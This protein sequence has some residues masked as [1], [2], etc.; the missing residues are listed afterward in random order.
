MR[1][2]VLGLHLDLLQ[3]RP[4]GC[5]RVR[6]LHREGAP[7]VDVDQQSQERSASFAPARSKRSMLVRRRTR[8]A[9]AWKPRPSSRGIQGA[10]KI[11]LGPPAK[12]GYAGKLMQPWNVVENVP[13]DVLISSVDQGRL[14]WSFVRREP[15][16]D[17]RQAC[18]SSGGRLPP[19][20]APSSSTSL[21]EAQRRRRA[22]PDQGQAGSQKHSHS[23]R[24]F[25]RP[26]GI[27]ICIGALSH[28]LRHDV[29]GA[30]GRLL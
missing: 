12:W 3:S 20:W 27:L 25:L 26:R 1:L 14:K 11:L 10:G 21:C 24:H 2:Q 28:A 8:A 19:A 23:D 30:P 5:N 13:R 9:S 18:R 17:R 22:P 29:S 4:D 15:V 6:P 16:H 7:L